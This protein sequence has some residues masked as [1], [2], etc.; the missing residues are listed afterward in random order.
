MDV[1]PQNILIRQNLVQEDWKGWRVYIADF[2][3]SCDY[4]AQGHSQSDERT[5]LTPRYCAPEVYNF[6]LR[7]R[8]ADI[9]SLGCVF[10]E[11][12]TVLTGQ[13][14]HEFAEFR[15][16]ESGNDAFHATLDRVALWCES[17]FHKG[18]GDTHTTSLRIDSSVCALVEKMVR[19]DPS[20]RPTASEL[21]A[22]FTGLPENDS[23]KTKSNCCGRPPEPYII[24]KLAS[25]HSQNATWLLTR[26]R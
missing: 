8:A 18:I 6:E 14:P 2:G 22:F 13:H 7:G 23:C 12:M 16:R 3:L 5:F 20:Q 9:F 25:T 19:M 17:Y 10:L 11:I 1:K 4:T 24:A 15:S 21:H 26:P